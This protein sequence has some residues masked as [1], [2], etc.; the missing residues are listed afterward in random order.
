MADHIVREI[1]EGHATASDGTVVL[2]GQIYMRAKK[3]TDMEHW[4]VD[5]RVNG[6]GVLTIE[7][8]S[9]SGVENI[10]DHADAVR[11]C[12]MH[13]LSFIGEP[14]L[15]AALSSR[16]REIERLRAFA[17]WAV[18]EGPFNG[19]S[20]DG[21]DIQEK[22]VQ[23]GILREVKYDPSTHGPNDVDAEAGDP[24]FEFTFSEAIDE[25][26]SD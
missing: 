20:L 5:V 16:D 24:W 18:A 14:D 9:M 4:G 17:R 6:Q 25:Q 1:V 22:A 3:V 13:L 12:A 19:C 15:S 7:S 21:G 10:Q 8:N 23:F 2:S 11:T 26:I